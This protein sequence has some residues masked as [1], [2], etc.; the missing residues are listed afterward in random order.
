MITQGLKCEW[1]LIKKGLIKIYNELKD[2][3]HPCFNS[4]K[5]N[6]WN[7]N[8]NIIN[9]VVV[10]ARTI[11]N[12]QPVVQFVGKNP[13]PKNN[14]VAPPQNQGCN[15]SQEEPRQRQQNYKPKCQYTPLGKPIETMLRQLVSSNLVTLPKTSNYEPQ[16]KPP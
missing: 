6:F 4:D 9:D 7:K 15:A 3:P 11:K 10:D 5:P 14:M 13:S 2:G 16:V 1:A 12:A 8:K